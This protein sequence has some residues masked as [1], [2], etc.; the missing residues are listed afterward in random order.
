MPDREDAAEAV[1]VVARP[2][3]ARPVVVLT[4][5]LSPHAGVTVSV[6]D[7]GVRLGQ[8]LQALRWWKGSSPWPIVFADN[9]GLPL[10]EELSSEAGDRC[11]LL[12]V[13]PPPAQLIGTKGKGVGEALI[14]KT[15]MERMD[16]TFNVIV[17]VTG[18]LTVRNIH[19]CFS[20]VDG[21]FVTC[22]ISPDLKFSDSRVFAGDRTSVGYLV[23]RV[24]ER[25]NDADGRYFEHELAAGALQLF[26]E[27]VEFRAFHK[28]PST[29]GGSGTMGSSYSGPL[30]DAARLAHDGV[31]RFIGWRHLSL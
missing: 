29:R 13:D 20:S 8:Y 9:S 4:S 28:L 21:R 5:T 1:P 14:I 31:R 30:H 24:I 16:Q 6:K 3:V 22:K 11:T 10:P 12:A 17:K 26:S 15:A 18:R 7:E 25:S 23:D 2:L 27:G 19:S